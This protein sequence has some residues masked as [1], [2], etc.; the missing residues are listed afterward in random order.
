MTTPKATGAASTLKLNATGQAIRG[1]QTEH[2]LVSRVTVDDDKVTVI[3]A[4]KGKS[5]DR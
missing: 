1:G 5:D 4:T 2:K 3:P